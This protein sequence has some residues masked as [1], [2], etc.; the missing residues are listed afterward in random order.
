VE[1]PYK[2]QVVYAQGYTHNVTN[3]NELP[4]S[5]SATAECFAVDAPRIQEYPAAQGFKDLTV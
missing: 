3:Q 1:E 5:G 2:F 4:G